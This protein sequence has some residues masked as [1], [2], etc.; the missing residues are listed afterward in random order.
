MQARGACAHRCQELYG[1]SSGLEP[2]GL[3]VLN[4]PAAPDS[5]VRRLWSGAEVWERGRGGCRVKKRLQKYGPIPA[6]REVFTSGLQWGVFGVSPAGLRSWELG[7]VWKPVAS[8]IRCIRAEILAHELRPHSA[9]R[10][11][12]ARSWGDVIP[13]QP[14]G[15]KQARAPISSEAASRDV[16][17]GLQRK[18]ILQAWF[19]RFAAQ[20]VALP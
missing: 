20:S 1:H 7:D 10:A 14:H 4:S 17:R 8:F 5:V 9:G 18:S 12:S 3:Q 2:V 19:S 15:L 6:Q 16:P 13:L 11:C